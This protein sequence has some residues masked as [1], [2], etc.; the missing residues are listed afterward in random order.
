MQK[1]ASDLLSGKTALVTGG[2]SG[3]GK[4]IAKAMIE[5]GAKV[6]IIGRNAE[7]LQKA[8]EDIGGRS[9]VVD[10][11]DVPAMERAIEQLSE[12]E[13]IDILVNSAGTHGMDAFLEVT[14]KTFDEVMNANVKA[15]YFISQTVARQ[16]I[17]KGIAGHILNVSSASSLKPSW[18]PY[19]I[20]KRAV[21]GITQGMAHKLIAYGI[22]VNGIAPGPTATPMMHRENDLNWPGNPSGRM[23]TPEEIAALALFMVSGRGD[24][25]VG[26]TFFMTGG[27]GTV[28]IDK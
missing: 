2:S 26:D 18:T 23:S 1:E 16:M 28:C 11:N 5:A 8:A 13:N 9:L 7:K 25:I 27:S 20:S 10:I 15:L 6:Y 14:E 21:N 22:V 19:E 4:A 17:K 24:G 3:I 12:Q